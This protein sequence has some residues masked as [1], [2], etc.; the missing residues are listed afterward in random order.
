MYETIKTISKSWCLSAIRL[1]CTRQSQWHPP[2][3]NFLKHC[4]S[5]L[6]TRQGGYP[7]EWQH[8]L[9]KNHYQV[10]LKITSTERSCQS[11]FQVKL[12]RRRELDRKH[13]RSILKTN[14]SPRRQALLRINRPL[15]THSKPTASAASIADLRLD[16][17]W[18][19]AFRHL[20]RG[21]PE[22]P[23]RA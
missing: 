2:P 4:R 3:R 9:N 12:P 16:R 18:F 15:P 8:L 7:W 5:E 6:R 13:T 23:M 11:D 21:W 14:W 17:F 22:L 19:H 1:T 20:K 10:V